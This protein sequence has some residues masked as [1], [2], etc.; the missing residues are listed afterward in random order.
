MFRS[1]CSGHCVSQ[2][3]G[4][5]MELFFCQFPRHPSPAW[6]RERL[7]HLKFC[8]IR[9]KH[10]T[11]LKLTNSERFCPHGSRWGNRQLEHITQTSN[12]LPRRKFEVHVDLLVS[13]WFYL[14]REMTWEWYRA[15]LSWFA[16]VHFIVKMAGQNPLHYITPSTH[17][18]FM[19]G[20]KATQSVDDIR[21]VQGAGVV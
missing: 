2:I 4:S 7:T 21:W 19:R 16:D 6:T 10:V 17:V 20:F 3:T 14:W 8:L 15:V 9:G 11:L 5:S 13:T 18:I 1:L 12:S